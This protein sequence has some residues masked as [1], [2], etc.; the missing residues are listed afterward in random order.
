MK[1]VIVLALLAGLAAVAPAQ[2]ESLPAPVVNTNSF[3]IVSNSRY[4]SHSGFTSSVPM[5]VL[6]NILWAMNRAPSLGSAYRE[7][8]VATPS[9]VYLWDST[10]N[11][12]RVHL[13]G[14]HRYS[15][16]SAFE[17]GIAVES[18]EEAG[19]A[20]DA[21]LMASVA[22][23]RPES[24][25][26]S[27]C[28][29][30]FA[31]NYA[32]ANWDPAH[33]I[34]MVNVYGRRTMTGLTDSCQAASSDSSLPRPVTVGASPYE[35]VLDGLEMHAE[36]DPP[37]LELSVLGQLLWSGFGVTPHMTTN[38]RRGTT[39]ASAVANYYLTRRIYAVGDTALWRYHNRVPPGTGLTTSDHRLEWLSG[40][41]L[42][43][44]LRSA[45]ARVP[46]APDYVVLCVADTND[47]WQ[48][49]EAGFAAFQMLVQARALP[50]SPE[51]LYGHILAPLTTAER[52]AIQSALGLPAADWP[53]VVFSVGIPPRP[54]V[55]EPGQ[56]AA[57][58]TPGVIGGGIAAS[59]GVG[60]FDALGRRVSAPRLA[61]GVYYE[62]SG[63][64]RRRLV[65]VR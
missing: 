2:A 8:Y 62:V 42:R 48:T 38:N 63:A 10:A 32:N 19:G 46:I 3:E 26:V 17:V 37:P 56:G 59:V 35:E 34:N 61:P 25:T 14:N 39:I 24:A 16:N 22:F 27:S 50:L 33:T 40:G 21:G 45:S 13:A 5:Q 12:L 11:V 28:P 18:D 1:N 41:D 36:F 44:A 55:T 58:V 23:W 65:V 53:A 30:A 60:T 20:I 57:P 47:G 7:Y 9:N 64:G 52:G 51:G 31:A 43:Q 4:S 29:M 6:A 54:G 49:I 15:T